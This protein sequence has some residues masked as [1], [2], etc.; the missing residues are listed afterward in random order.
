M[1]LGFSC[2]HLYLFD[3]FELIFCLLGTVFLIPF[4]KTP[5][6]KNKKLIFLS[7][8]HMEDCYRENNPFPRY[9]FYFLQRQ[10]QFF[11]FPVN[12]E[13]LAHISNTLVV[14]IQTA[15]KYSVVAQ[16]THKYFS[17]LIPSYQ[18]KLALSVNIC[19]CKHTDKNKNNS[20]NPHPP[21]IS[22]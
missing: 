13:F 18:L 15:T 14:K 17:H 9:Y 2:P 7:I 1:Q 3:K 6:I 8:A 21:H 16:A 10:Y 11:I 12:C 20:S 19:S 22:L 5:F 4:F